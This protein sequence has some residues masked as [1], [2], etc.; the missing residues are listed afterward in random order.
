MSKRITPR[1]ILY[2]IYALFGASLFLCGYIY[3]KD[4]GIDYKGYPRLRYNWQYIMAESPRHEVHYEGKRFSF[5][6][7]TLNDNDPLKVSERDDGGFIGGNWLGLNWYYNAPAPI[8]TE[9]AGYLGGDAR[10]TW[11]PSPAFE[12]WLSPAADKFYVSKVYKTTLGD[13]LPA[14]IIIVKAKMNG[15]RGNYRYLVSVASDRTL[16]KIKSTLGAAASS[17]PLSSGF[18]VYSDDMR[19]VSPDPE[20]DFL[21]F[22]VFNHLI[23][24]FRFNKQAQ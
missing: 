4:T 11:T 10:T 8:N 3:L 18:E 24:T 22:C 7:L 20:R 6:Y 1:P 17:K 23:K 2:T 9:L 21:N 13:G 14:A 5:S 12:R 16:V 19:P 15:L